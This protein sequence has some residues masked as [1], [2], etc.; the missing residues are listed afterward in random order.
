MPRPAKRQFAAQDSDDATLL[1]SEIVEKIASITQMSDRRGGC[2]S[3]SVVPMVSIIEK[4]LL[5][6]VE[7]AGLVVFQQYISPFKRNEKYR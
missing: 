7:A 5:F 3:A 6:P 2:A 1:P 4:R